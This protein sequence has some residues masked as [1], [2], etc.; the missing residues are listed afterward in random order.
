LRLYAYI[1]NYELN[2]AELVLR[3]GEILAERGDMTKEGRLAAPIILRRFL[4]IVTEMKPPSVQISRADPVEVCV[5]LTASDSASV[6]L[7]ESVM[8]MLGAVFLR[9][10]ETGGVTIVK[11]SQTQ[12][13]KVKCIVGSQTREISMTFSLVYHP[14][15]AGLYEAVPYIL[16][17]HEAIPDG[18]IQSLGPGVIGMTENYLNMP[19]RREGGD[20]EITNP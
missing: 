1:A 13:S 2:H 7:P 20:F 17:A 18:L 4:R 5:K 16:I 14:M 6:I 12:G 9:S 11:Y 15:P 8:G 19:F 3:D 10:R